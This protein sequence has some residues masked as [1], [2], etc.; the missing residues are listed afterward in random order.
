MNCRH[1]N[2]PLEHVFIDLGHQPP[3]NA[4]LSPEQLA[5]P[6]ITYPLKV[7]VCGQCWLVQLPSH[8]D[9]GELFTPDYAYF[10]SIS[11]SWVAHARTY[12]EVMAE[13]L[14]LD[15]ASFVVE[16]ASNDGYLLQFVQARDIPC[17]GIEPTTSTAQAAR[18]LGIETLEEFFGLELA[19]RLASERRSADLLIVNNVL[20][21][22][23]DINDF[24]AGIYEMLAQQGVATLEFPHLLK[25]VEGV[26]FDTIYH[27]HYSYLSLRAVAG[28]FEKAGLKIFDVEELPTHGGSLR[29]FAARKEAADRT[30]TPRVAAL[31]EAERQA[32]VDRPEF[33]AGLQSRAEQTKNDLLTFLLK[34]KRAGKTV[35]AYGAAAKGNTLLN[36]AGVKPDLLAF[37]CD[38]APSKQGRFLPG[39]HLPVLPPEALREQ[40]PDFVLILPWNIKDEIMKFHGYVHEWGGRFVVAAPELEVL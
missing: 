17:L 32:G 13:R 4:Y 37:V 5:G 7:Y 24:V 1:C 21:H 27:E 39:S 20:A 34:Q 15:G 3:S 35:A 8:A 26:Q 19:R 28:I 9:A 6:E 29:I 10:S 30:V 14:G 40:R 36:F 18:K 31:L 33:Y 25:L 22:V 12:V 23:P 38:A 2:Q 11:A 16:I